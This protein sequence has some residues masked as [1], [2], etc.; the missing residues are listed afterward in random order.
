MEHY[1][2][3]AVSD[4]GNKVVKDF[5]DSV[6]AYNYGATFSEWG[7]FLERTNGK[8]VLIGGNDAFVMESMD[9]GK[10]LNIND[11]QIIK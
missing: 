5:E 3:I 2:V 10:T 1:R 8:W 4:D 9:C 11:L 6:E 7:L